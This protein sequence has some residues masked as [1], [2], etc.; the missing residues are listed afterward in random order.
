MKLLSVEEAE[1]TDL[2]LLTVEEA[3]RRLGTGPRFV[4]R[5]VAE[6]RIDFVKLGGTKIR[7]EEP[8]LEAFIPG[9]A[10]TGDPEECCFDDRTRPV[11][12]VRQQGGGRDPHLCQPNAG[13]PS[14]PL[15]VL[16]T[17]PAP[18]PRPF[19]A[20]T[21]VD[22][23]RVRSPVWRFKTACASRR[24]RICPANWY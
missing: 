7:F 15:T 2:K 9:V 22:E 24:H 8:V 6:R 18:C 10:A 14:S 1:A 19:I 5:L 16:G 20:A 23:V 12:G 4:R 17:P 3:A 11:F 21:A 13:R